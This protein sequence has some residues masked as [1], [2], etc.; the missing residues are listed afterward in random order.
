MKNLHVNVIIL[1][2]F[3]CISACGT[4][5]ESAVVEAKA[6]IK[7]RLKDPETARFLDLYTVKSPTTINGNQNITV[8][9]V[10]D[11]KNGF[12]AY[13]GGTR[14]IVRVTINDDFKPLITDATID[15]GTKTPLFDGDSTHLQTPFEYRHWNVYC[16][17]S[18]HAPTFTGIR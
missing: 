9:G 8:C 4:V 1:L 11:G 7:S 13:T 17:D 2:F 6:I 3:T 14:F 18:T 15:D 12:N 10:V 16:L 5:E